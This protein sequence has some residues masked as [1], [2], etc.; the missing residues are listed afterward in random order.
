MFRPDP[1]DPIDYELTVEATLV[2]WAQRFNVRRILFDPWQMQS[3]AQ[4]LTKRVEPNMHPVIEDKA[5]PIFVGVDTW[6]APA[7]LA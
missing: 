3:T 4:R 1:N 5:L 7:A 2:A 6:L